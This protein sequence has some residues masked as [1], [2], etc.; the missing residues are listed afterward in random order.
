MFYT[1]S[2]PISF[3]GV[4]PVPGWSTDVNDIGLCPSRNR[5]SR[6]PTLQMSGLGRGHARQSLILSK[7]CIR[8][9][10][11]QRKHTAPGVGQKERWQP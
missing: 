4:A 9:R 8:G 2:R 11:H 5:I 6:A 7:P 10:P 1:W 3:S